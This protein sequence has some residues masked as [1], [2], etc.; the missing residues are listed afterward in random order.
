MKG[1]LDRLR[2]ITDSCLPTSPTYRRG[3]RSFQR[4]CKT[5]GP[6]NPAS[7]LTGARKKEV[8]SASSLSLSF[9]LRVHYSHPSRLS[10]S[11]PDI[12]YTLR[13]DG[14]RPY[15]RTHRSEARSVGV[16]REVRMRA[17]VYVCTHARVNG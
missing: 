11:P 7:A 1:M 5:E 8:P 15:T 6:R 16:S 2:I 12:R 17:C 10:C 4:F 13:F 3:S 9:M 14:S